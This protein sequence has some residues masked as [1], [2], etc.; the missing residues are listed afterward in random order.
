MVRTDGPST[1][2]N[3]KVRICVDLKRLNEAVERE[4]YVLPTLED[5]ATE[6]VGSTVYS[7]LDA[8][9]GF[10][11]LPLDPESSRLTTFITP[12]GRYCFRRLPFGITSAPEI[13]QRR[14]VRLL[15][16]LTGVK[17]VMDD[18]L[19][20]G[21]EKNH[22]TRLRAVLDRIRPSGLKL[23]KAKCHFRKSTVEYFGHELSKDGV[24]VQSSKVKAIKDLPAPE[25]ITELRRLLGMTNYLGKFL[26]DL[27]SKTQPLNE[28]LR[29]DTAWIWG[30]AQEEA[31]ERI[32]QS[33]CS[34]SVLAFY[35]VSK[36]TVVSADASSYGLGGGG[37]LL[38]QHGDQLV[39]VAYCSRTLTE[40]ERRYA[41]IEKELSC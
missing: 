36:P 40:A 27:S 22:E 34:T 13:F 7:T 39:P 31:F 33:V 21:N 12:F 20:Y 25:N 1:Q 23:N 28:L 5:I 29:K 32:K 24:H 11:Q 19:V 9:S 6:L 30:P 18:I 14:M 16:G 8:S 37:A 41:Q 35:D 3:D 17:T 4:K 2:E 26:P 10:W 15:D 38:Q